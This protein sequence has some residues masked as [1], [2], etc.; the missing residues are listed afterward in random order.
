MSIFEQNGTAVG[1]KQYTN[2]RRVVEFYVAPAGSTNEID[3]HTVALAKPGLEAVELFGAAIPTLRIS[4]IDES[5]IDNP[6]YCYNIFTSYSPLIWD[7]AVIDGMCCIGLIP[8]DLK[9]NLASG[10]TRVYD[11]VTGRILYLPKGADSQT[12]FESFLE[13]REK[14]RKGEIVDEH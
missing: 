8:G 1:F 7:G 14:V 13:Y 9:T 5:G 4:N 3:K 10:N 6:L 11:N 12:F 2:N